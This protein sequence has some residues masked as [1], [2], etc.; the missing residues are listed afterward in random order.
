MGACDCRWLLPLSSQLSS[1]PHMDL[2]DGEQADG[3]SAAIS[4]MI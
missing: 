1:N 2:P 4:P 3:C